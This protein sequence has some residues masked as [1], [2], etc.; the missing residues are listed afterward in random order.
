MRMRALSVT[1]LFSLSIAGCLHRDGR[2]TDCRW[3]GE[4]HVHPAD[5]RHLSAD[6]EFAED[7]AIRYAD[8][9]YGLR[10]P[11][12]ISGDVYGAAREKCMASLF[13]QIAKEH[14]VPVGVVTGVL[15]RNRVGV[16]LAINLPFL[17]FYGLA[18]DQ[19]YVAKDAAADS[20]WR[21]FGYLPKL[22]DGG[23]RSISI[24]SS[25]CP[26]MGP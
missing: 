19:F 21:V 23:S 11:D 17:L 3:P 4:V 9:H 6:A 1:I 8:R 5:A 25:S 20:L 26:G 14:G 13:E 2:N 12:H 24:G 15:G 22:R 10:T 16:D 7:L 18:G